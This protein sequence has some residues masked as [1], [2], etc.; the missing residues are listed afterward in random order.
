M[1]ALKEVRKVAKALGISGFKIQRGKDGTKKSK[2]VEVL[3]REIHKKIVKQQAQISKDFIKTCKQVLKSVRSTGTRKPKQ[4]LR[5]PRFEPQMIAFVPPPPNLLKKK[6]SPRKSIKKAP[7][8]PPP[9]PPPLLLKKKISPRKSMKKSPPKL[10]L[11]EQLIIELK[12][13]LE[14]GKIT[15]LG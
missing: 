7:P 14:K 2:S 13:K 12:N 1:Q 4:Q 9:P 6:T 11:R 10:G 3:Q 8:P 15:R 5:V